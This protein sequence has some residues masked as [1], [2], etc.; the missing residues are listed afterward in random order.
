MIKRKWIILLTVSALAI[1]YCY[2]L[3]N[4]NAIIVPSVTKLIPSLKADNVTEEGEKHI[5]KSLLKQVPEVCQVVFIK[6]HKAAG[7]TVQNILTRFAMARDLDLLLP[8]IGPTINEGGPFIDP[9]KVIHHPEG[10][11]F[12]ILSSHLVYNK[13]QLAKYFPESAMRVTIIR[14]PMK[15]A[16]SAL[17]FYSLVYPQKNYLAGVSKHPDDPIGGFLLHPEDFFPGS[18]RVCAEP[19]S[20]ITNRMSFDLGFDTH[21]FTS[22]KT[23]RTKMQV[24]LNQ[25]ERDFDIVLISDYF[26]ES[27]VLLRRLL[28]WKI[29]DIIYLKINSAQI[30]QHSV[31][32]RVPELNSTAFLKFRHCNKLDYELYEYFLPAFIDKTN[33]QPY[34]K[35]EVTFFKKVQKQVGDFCSQAKINETFE[36]SKSEWTDQFSVSY[37]DCK[38]MKATEIGLMQT[39]RRMQLKRY[40]EIIKNSQNSTTV[41]SS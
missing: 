2:V 27:M 25:I 15:H 7:S 32:A 20:Y 23:N 5:D 40:E 10:K 29:Q 37:D 17:R 16:I 21:S 28:G 3:I 12:D 22:S 36:V 38:L 26:D 6:V 13:Q 33:K 34:F 1:F 14:E 41:P 39:A 31:W 4:T 24:F 8:I 18:K 11:L 30:K 35:E 19:N 9:E